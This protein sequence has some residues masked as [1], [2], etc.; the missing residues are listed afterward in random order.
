[1]STYPLFLSPTSHKVR[2][3]LTPGANKEN[4]AYGIEN[5]DT[6]DL[7]VGTTKRKC[8]KRIREHVSN[9]NSTK[10]RGQAKVYQSV[11]E[12]L[13]SQQKVVA[14][15]LEEVPPDQDLGHK[16]K[17][18]I[19]DLR[20]TL[21]GNK[22]GRP[23]KLK[24]RKLSKPLPRTTPEK[25]YPL[26]NRAGKITAEWTPSVRKTKDVGFVYRFKD[27]QTGKSYV[28]QTVQQPPTK[29]MRR[30][31]NFANQPEKDNDR[32]FYQELRRRPEDFTV[33]LIAEVPKEELDAAEREL[34]KVKSAFTDGY[35]GN[36]GAAN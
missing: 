14:K 24:Q 16:E 21:N 27:N 33:G 4:V 13:D 26:R 35:N 6:G 22:G 34:I 10:S 12:A 2:V 32:E 36:Q 19:A 8:S 30:H 20:P 17:A 5:Q 3:Q 31:L 15:I 7:Y 28:G 23:V 1:M 11:R 18:L 25:S 29:R 9:L